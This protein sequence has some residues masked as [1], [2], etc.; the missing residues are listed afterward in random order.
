MAARKNA[1]HQEFADGDD[2]MPKSPDPVSELAESPWQISLPDRQSAGLARM[3]RNL[4][5]VVRLIVALAWDASRLQTLA[6]LVLETLSALLAACGLLAT[7]AV[8]SALLASGSDTDR[9]SQAVPAIGLTVGLLVLRQVVVFGATW[10]QASLRPA[11]KRVAEERLYRAAV[12]ADLT[13]FDDPD[14]HDSMGRARDRGFVYVGMATDRLVEL[15][16]AVMALIGAAGVVSILHPVLLPMLL[17]SA[18]P[19]AWATLHS[20]RTMH[21]S[22]ER[23]S[24]VHRRMSTL[25]R[26]LADRQSAAEIRAFT[27]QETLLEERRQLAE[28]VCFEDSRVGR[29]EGKGRLLGQAVSGLSMALSYGI[30]CWLLYLGVMPLAAAG[31]AVIAMRSGQSALGS[32]ALS[33]GKLF[34]QGLYVEDYSEFIRKAQSSV[35][36]ASQEVVPHDFDRISVSAVTFTYPG[37]SGAAV[38]DV[39]LSIKSGQVVAFV[40]ENGSGK[41]TLAK[42]IAGLYLPQHGVIRWGDVDLST[43]DESSIYQYVGYI[44]Q[45]PTQ[46]PFS[47]RSNITIGRPDREDPDDRELVAAARRS[48]AEE[49]VSRLREGYETLLSKEFRGGADLSGG[50]WQR[51]SVARGFYRDARLLICDEPSAAMDPRAEGQVFKRIHELAEERTTILITHRLSGVRLADCIFFL[52]HGRIVEQGRHSDLMAAQ[53]KYFELYTLQASS[54]SE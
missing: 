36:P 13:A 37:K 54:F 9:L 23:F 11:V 42:L 15:T 35:R 25:A 18:I 6:V 19:P 39:S 38:S 32:L 27:A 45:T 28:A 51:F 29:T 50:E 1:S 48:T 10:V 41:S 22:V 52:E 12:Y 31:G 16:S 44:S 46:W 5:S 2:T 49:V 7:T 3:L 47:A 34:E 53:G 26:L 43:V 40:G 30:L 4:P 24:A 33:L 14:F 8:F 17:A 21:E 20:A